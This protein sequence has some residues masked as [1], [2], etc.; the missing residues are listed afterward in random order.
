MAMIHVPGTKLYTEKGDTIKNTPPKSRCMTM[1]Q[2]P[3]VK[4]AKE[5][6][7]IKVHYKGEMIGTNNTLV[8]FEPGEIRIN[9]S[10]Y[11][12]YDKENMNLMT[13]LEKAPNRKVSI[14][15]FKLLRI[16]NIGRKQ[17]NEN[18][19]HKWIVSRLFISPTENT[20]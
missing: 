2:A 16:P 13:H 14:Q 1:I 5:Q 9:K 6:E 3:K 18:H 20:I 19:K 12:V 15:A 7:R 11:P 8:L 4:T 10:G 17:T